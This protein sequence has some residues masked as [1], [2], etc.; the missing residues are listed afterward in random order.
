MRR[1]RRQGLLRNGAKFT[2]LKRE[3]GMLLRSTKQP[4]VCTACGGH[5]KAQYQ[6]GGAVL[7]YGSEQLDSKGRAPTIAGG[8]AGG[9]RHPALPSGTLLLIPSRPFG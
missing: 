3:F 9:R 5:S 6:K 7:L 4:A 1:A 2:Q 8:E